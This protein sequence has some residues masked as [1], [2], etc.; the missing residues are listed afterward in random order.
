VNR[1]VLVVDDDAGMCMLLE[2][3]GP[4]TCAPAPVQ[5]HGA[6]MTAAYPHLALFDYQG[7]GIAILSYAGE[8]YWGLTADPDLVPALD[9]LAADL[10]AAFAELCDAAG[11]EPRGTAVQWIP[12]ASD[13][14][15]RG[16]WAAEME[17][18]VA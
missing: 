9:D 17:Q 4:G 11:V 10:S 3:E 7:L 2:D 13:G 18:A 8:L 14:Q 6:R 1:R 5:R 15:Q 12:A 16:P